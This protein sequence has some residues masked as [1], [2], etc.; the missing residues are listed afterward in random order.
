MAAGMELL[1]RCDVVIM[2]GRYGTSKGMAAELIEARGCG[3]KI[4]DFELY[5][6]RRGIIAA[7]HTATRRAFCF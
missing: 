6:K 3:K 4:I 2:V 5:T 1:H 7:V